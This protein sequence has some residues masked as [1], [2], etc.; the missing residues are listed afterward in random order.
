MYKCMYM[1]KL[2]IWTVPA[3]GVEEIKE[4]DGGENSAMIHCKNFCK[5][6][7]VTPSNNNK[8]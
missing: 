5:C 8:K 6:H 1:E 2:D 3:M 7:N 4:N